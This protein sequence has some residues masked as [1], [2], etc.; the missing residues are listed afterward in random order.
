MIFP[1]SR[2]VPANY[3][4]SLFSKLPANYPKNVRKNTIY[5]PKN[6]AKLYFTYVFCIFSEFLG[7]FVGNFENSENSQFAGSFLE[8]GK[9]IWPFLFY[10]VPKTV[11]GTIRTFR[12]FFRIF[13]PRGNFFGGPIFLENLVESAAIRLVQKSSKSEPSSAFFGRLK[14]RESL[15]RTSSFKI[16][17]ADTE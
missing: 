11:Y 6:T 12:E 1:F 2:N 7:K 13:R 14:F 3:K 17:Y 9:I 5:T 10:L 8:N 16:F 15:S 4:F